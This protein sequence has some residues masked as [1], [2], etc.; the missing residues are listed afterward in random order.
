M[1]AKHSFDEKCFEL[2]EYFMSEPAGKWTKEDK[3]EL[4]EDIQQ[5]IE[6]FMH[7]DED[8]S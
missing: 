7:E 6:N 1:R 2:A 3:N 5:T 8:E 4:A